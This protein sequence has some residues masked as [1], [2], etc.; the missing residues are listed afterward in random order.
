VLGLGR[1]GLWM[2][3]LASTGAWAAPAE[4]VSETV[5]V[6]VDARWT[7]TV[8]SAQPG[9][10]PVEGAVWTYRPEGSRGGAV[11]AFAG[12]NDG[13]SEAITELGLAALADRHKVPVAVVAMGPSILEAQ[14][15]PETRDDRR[16]C[17]VGCDVGGGAWVAEV[18]VPW[19]VSQDG[20]LSLMLGASSG[21]RGAVSL[22]AAFVD[23]PGGVPPLCAMSGAYDLQALDP[24]TGEYRVH[25]QVLGERASFPDRWAQ[26][27]PM[28]QVAPLRGRRVLLVHGAE[29]P[30]VPWSQAERFAA[31]LRGV[32]ARVELFR[33]PGGQHDAVTWS[34]GARACFGAALAAPEGRVVTR[35]LVV[36]ALVD[37]HT[38][39]TDAPGT[40]TGDLDAALA[41]PV[42]D[43]A[44]V[45][46]SVLDLQTG[47]PRYERN[48]DRPLNPA[49]VQKVVTTLVVL[50]HLDPSDT[51]T[52]TV[53]R[54][55][56]LVEGTLEGDLVL[57]GGGDP[58]LVLER[59]WKLALD[60]RNEGV[61]VIRGDVVVDAG[62]LGPLAPV[63][64]W[65]AGI[66]GDE[67]PAYAAPV[68]GLSMNYNAMAVEVRPGPA[69]GD[70]LRVQVEW[71]NDYVEVVN[72]G[73]TLPAR[74]RQSVAFA[75]EVAGDT[76]RVVVTGGLAID[77]DPEREYLNVAD[78]ARYTGE[79]FVR[80]FE[81]LGGRVEGTVRSGEAS[82]DDEVVTRFA[83]LPVGTLLALMNKWSSNPI[84]EHLLRAT[85]ARVLH[86]GTPDG[87]VRL[88]RETLAS[89]GISV[90]RASMFNGSG[91][92]RQG[93]VPPRLITEVY[94]SA[95]SDPKVA[96][97]LVSSLAIWGVD[98][99]ARRHGRGD[100]NAGMVRVKTG[101]LDG[102]MALSGVVGCPSHPGF[103][104]ALLV[105]EASPAWRVRSVWSPFLA[106]LSSHCPAP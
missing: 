12:W 63:P 78:P 14:L 33:V 64:G 83:S 6:V 58:G 53:R 18:V 89:R 79:A 52:T 42:L 91:L 35:D 69:V 84:A 13:A 25:A 11:L 20:P 57:E 87:A 44:E 3:A 72:R 30:V 81:S 32:G 92:A 93:R 48:A 80:L 37:S 51:L 106:A 43:G 61:D 29:D 34:A 97:D 26:A 73:T 102:V 4:V 28:R 62:L 99:T 77:D 90:D 21:A 96:P 36:D 59:L 9:D 86:D 38:G 2:A 16:W 24:S 76:Q 67:A 85:A 103:A 68:S 95:L 101:S 82:P 31:A 41:D 49:S 71:P 45:G 23:L 19:L 56:E 54:T 1:T 40:L 70:P 75:R 10:T 46:V 98:G 94:R 17:G 27:D 22:P 60:V 74:R 50:S 65:P 88:V 105:N 104:F 47:L 7:R 15:Y 39:E 66:E 5:E 100:D 8:L 55:G